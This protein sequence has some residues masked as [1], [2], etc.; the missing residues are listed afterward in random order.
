[1]E[2]WSG[3]SVVQGGRQR[4]V[5]GVRLSI[6]QWTAGSVCALAGRVT[7]IRTGQ[8]MSKVFA[9]PVQ[10]SLHPKTP[11][12]MVRDPMVAHLAGSQNRERRR[13]VAYL[14]WV[15]LC[16]VVVLGTSCA[17]PARLGGPT[18]PHQG[19]RQRSRGACGGQFRGRSRRSSRSGRD[20]RRVAV[21]SAGVRGRRTASGSRRTRAVG[22]HG[23]SPTVVH[24]SAPG[25]DTSVGGRCAWSSRPRC[26]KGRGIDIE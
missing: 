18:A 1:M 11:V 15:A 12:R 3:R 14:S 4:F 5:Q 8:P 9:H 19:F 24:R 17:G 21:G 6:Y 7:S 16:V 22:D 10:P 20:P 25:G 2:V 13:T 23:Q 26:P